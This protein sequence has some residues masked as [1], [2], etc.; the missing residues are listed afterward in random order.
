M[1]LSVLTENCA[2]GRFLAEH[3]L[4]YLIEIDD[5]K[6]LFDTGHSDVFLK[7]ARQMGVDIEKEVQLVVLSH[8]HWDHGDGLQYLQNKR[9]ITH[10]GAFIRRFRKRDFSAVGLSLLKT[11]IEQRF[12][13][14]ETKNVFQ[15]SEHLFYLGEIPRVTEFEAQATPF[16]DEH[17]ND[18]VVPDD[19]AL[20]A[21]V[22][23]RLVVITGCSHSGICNIVEHAK[24]ATGISDVKTVLGGFHLKEQNEQTRRT[25]GYFKNEHVE[26]VYP[27]HCT[28]LPAL[29]AFYQAFQSTQLKTGMVLE[30]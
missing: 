5:R 25:I 20:A 15:I 28:A 12:D 16:V 4:S 27:S 23:D 6:I 18:D 17:K 19:S 8:G 3:G 22:N 24:K 10:P 11:E 7:N 14:T 21:I 2:G 30:F 9:L 13:L 29:S 1:K 26:Q